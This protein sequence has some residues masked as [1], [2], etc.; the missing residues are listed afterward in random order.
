MPVVSV[1]ELPVAERLHQD[2]S[3][4]MAQSPAHNLGIY[5]E[6]TAKRRGL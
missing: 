6:T 4:P 1:N 2:D 5:R 3:T